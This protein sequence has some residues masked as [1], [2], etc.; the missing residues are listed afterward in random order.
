MR[1]QQG[2]TLIE[3]MIVVLIVGILA[4]F[5]VPQYQKYV[6]RTQVSRVVMETSQL[7]TIVE[8]CA[9]QGIDE[10]ECKTNNTLKSDLIKNDS[11]S[12]KAAAITATF[13]SNTA[14]DV[15]N[16]TVTWTRD[17]NG[18]WT[19]STTV[20]QDLAPKSCISSASSVTSVSN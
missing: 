17:T 12:I 8:M 19:C 6:A 20:G 4:M 14:P 16:R 15:Q 1:S 5:A 2:F 18:S 3:L 11:L 13:S 9:L 10:N 7:R